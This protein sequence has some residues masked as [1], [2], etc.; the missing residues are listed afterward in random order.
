[1]SKPLLYVEE[2]T[3]GIID[4]VLWNAWVC[5]KLNGWQRFGKFTRYASERSVMLKAQRK[6]VSR[7]RL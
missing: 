7:A 6:C 4:W 3:L 5:T 1:M 2:K